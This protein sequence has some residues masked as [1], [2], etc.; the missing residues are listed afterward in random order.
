MIDLNDVLTALYSRL[1]LVG[2]DPVHKVSRPRN[3]DGSLVANPCYTYNILSLPP[4]EYCD[5]YHGTIIIC[6]FADNFSNG[7]PDVAKLT[8]MIKIAADELHRKPLTGS[9]FHVYSQY[10]QAPSGVLFDAQHPDEH[11]MS[12][13]IKI[14]LREE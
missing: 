2:G 10:I 8:S 3:D 13:R 7:A 6:A 4:G 14:N 5:I 11:Y 1:S 12:L 9:G